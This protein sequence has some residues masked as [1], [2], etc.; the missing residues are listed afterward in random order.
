MALP[1]TSPS[2]DDLQPDEDAIM[3]ANALH[4]NLDN[5]YTPGEQS[6]SDA[7]CALDGTDNH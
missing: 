5:D 1:S 7:D 2:D 6:Y 4:D 3:K